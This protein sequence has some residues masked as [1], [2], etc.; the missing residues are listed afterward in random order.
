M[1]F[2]PLSGEVHLLNLPA[3]ALLDTLSGRALL[4]RELTEHLAGDSSLDT[5][6]WAVAVGDALTTLDRAGLIEPRA[7]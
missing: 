5:D 3:L 2:S 7:P 6:E 1:V 4:A